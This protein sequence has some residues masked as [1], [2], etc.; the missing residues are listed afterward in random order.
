MNDF[1]DSSYD[2]ATTSDACRVPTNRV[3]ERRRR[4]RHLTPVEPTRRRRPA[5]RRVAVEP[6]TWKRRVDSFRRP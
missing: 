5:T 3:V 2:L 6:D 1:Q 4:E